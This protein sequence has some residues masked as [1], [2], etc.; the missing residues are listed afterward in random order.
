[1]PIM[2]L[3][4]LVS[5]LALCGALA[6][7]GCAGARGSATAGAAPRGSSANVPTQLPRKVRPLHY[8]ISVTPD[9]PNLRFAGRADIEIEVLEATD[10][11]TLNAFEL[12]FGNVSLD[13]AAGDAAPSLTPTS[14]R[15]D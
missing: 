14:V 7:G 3:S 11:I 8:T 12:E 10:S 5:S 1:M 15:V 13:R 2:R 9:A 4:I 6:L